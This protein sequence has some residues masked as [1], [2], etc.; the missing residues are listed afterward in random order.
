VATPCGICPKAAS[1]KP[2]PGIELTDR[3]WLV[4]EAYMR[5]KAGAPMP[6]DPVVQR[7]CGLIQH[8]ADSL[9]RG[10]M[11][12]VGRALTTLPILAVKGR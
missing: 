12:A 6:D 2:N 3:S 1:G 4:Y 5:Y 11:L 10:E 7:D 9:M 8:V